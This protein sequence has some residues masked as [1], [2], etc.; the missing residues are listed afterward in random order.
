MKIC[1]KCFESFPDDSGFCPFD[2]TSLEMP[3]DPWIGKTVTNKYRI[4]ERIGEGGMGIV[5][6]AIQFHPERQ[7]A[8]KILS[9][10]LLKDKAM[11][12]RFEREAMAVAMIQHEHIVAIY[13]ADSTEDGVPYIAMELLEGESLMD[14]LGRGRI[15]MQRAVTI[16]IQVCEALG[17]IHAMGI[18]H[19]D[20]KPENIFLTKTPDDG[21]CVKIFDFGIALL[22][23]KP[24]LTE[25]DFVVGTP[26]FMA[27]EI[28]TGKKITPMADLYSLGCIF[29]EMLCG[30]LPFKDT[31]PVVLVTKHVHELPLPPD[32][33]D[34]S[35]PLALSSMIMRLLAKNP[36][37][38]YQDAYALVNDLRSLN[39]MRDTLPAKVV[40]TEAAGKKRLDIRM[41]VISSP[42]A[43]HEKWK[44]FLRSTKGKSAEVTN[45]VA[46][47]KEMEALTARLGE[48]EAKEATLSEKLAKHE[49][50]DN[51]TKT[52][53]RRALEE[54][55]RELSVKKAMSQS[56]TAQLGEYDGKLLDLENRLR[57]LVAGSGIL[58]RE[59]MSPVAIK[60][61]EDA[62]KLASGWLRTFDKLKGHEEKKA[63]FEQ[64]IKDVE[65][66]VKEIHG[67]LQSFESQSSKTQV[68][69]SRLESEKL[70]I[71]NRLGELS[72]I[73]GEAE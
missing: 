73:F 66:Q 7:V 58:G 9:Q 45:A 39:M 33:K 20:L 15:D 42:S 70:E 57:G 62:G 72:V 46:L 65:F 49:T 68:D 67:R 21:D 37:L 28:I 53:L 52:R 13:D 17:P 30:E 4:I 60:D 18:I 1:Q 14:V 12:Q 26:E 35:V 59:R 2:G 40:K 34:S 10:K 6:R 50:S 48:I 51:E 27:P 25:K 56:E 5:Y 31:N 71:K 11:M 38:R 36:E 43:T 8:L 22:K 44:E 41:E 23:D 61:C 3:D 64:E 32:R 69:L 24:R 29:Y 63:A 16:V 47:I 54:L 19:R 55:A